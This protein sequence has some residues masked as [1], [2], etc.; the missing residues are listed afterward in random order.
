[1]P[2]DPKDEQSAPHVSTTDARGGTRTKVNRN[3]LAIS[4]PL[5][6]ILF[7]LIVGAGFFYSSQSGADDV[8][9]DK[10]VSGSTVS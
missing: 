5:V 7:A 9:G 6:V 1:M 2:T 10:V 4:L 8:N 3:V